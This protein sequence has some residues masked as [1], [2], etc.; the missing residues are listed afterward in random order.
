MTTRRISVHHTNSGPRKGTDHQWFIGEND[1]RGDPME[2]S[3]I[4]QGWDFGLI[5]ELFSRHVG[6][7]LTREE[8]RTLEREPGD[9]GGYVIA[10]CR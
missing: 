1:G 7:P 8:E 4:Y 3:L 6:R 2:F 9:C 5:R 10:D